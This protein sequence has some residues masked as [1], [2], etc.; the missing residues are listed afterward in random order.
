M[1]SLAFAGCTTLGV[2]SNGENEPVY[3]LR[4]DIGREELSRTQYYTQ[5]AEA[6]SLSGSHEKAEE[7]YRLALL[8]DPKF[9]NAHLKLSDEYVKRDK[10]LLAMIELNEAHKLEPDNLDIMRKTG[11][12]YLSAKIYSKARE[13]YQQMLVKN[14]KA[15]DAQWALFYIF[16]LEKK[17]GDALATI[18]RVQRNDSNEYKIAF[19]QAL[20]YKETHDYDEYAAL[21][22]K[23]ITLNPRDRQVLLEFVQDSY[24]KNQFNESTEALLN[25]SNTHEFDPQISQNL[26]Y[27]AVQSEN[28]KVALREL[29]KQHRV[30]NDVTVIEMKMAHVYYLMGDFDNAEKLYLTLINQNDLDEAKFYLAQIYI[31]QEKSEDAAFVLGK[32]SPTSEFF[33][34]ARAR[35]ALYKKSQ[36]EPDDAINVISDAFIQRP[37]QISIYK[38]Y[39]DFLI[40]DKKYVEALALLEKG[41]QQFPKDEELHLKMAFLHYRLNNQKSFKKQI[42]QALKINPQSAAAYAMLTELWYLKNKNVDEMIHFAKMATELKSNNK[43][44]KP[45]LAWALMQKDQSTEAVA[46]FEEYYEQ[47]PDESFFARSLSEVY[48]RGDVKQKAKELSILADWLEANDSLKSRFIFRDN[49]QQVQSE[50]YLVNPTRLPSSLENH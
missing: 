27:S 7:L 34:R 6:Y 24:S 35:L 16:K 5:M 41:L 19:E 46:I 21:L 13:V 8:H 14:N 22:Q 32:L 25:Y 15:D 11:D 47:N 29:Q 20:I 26:T 9:V 3:T 50:N 30:T 33:G 2:K 49:T 17:F 42:S 12:L 18:A 39:A 1:L 28:Y 37:D 38:T 36:N 23:A 4:S 44:I 10:F 48:K 40:E 45:I 31:S 43:N